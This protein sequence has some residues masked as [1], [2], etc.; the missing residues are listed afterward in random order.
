MIVPQGITTHIHEYGYTQET[1]LASVD[2]LVY[3]GS[4]PELS[5]SEFS[6]TAPIGADRRAIKGVLVGGCFVKPDPISRLMISTMERP[7][8]PKVIRLGIKFNALKMT[9]MAGQHDLNGPYEIAAIDSLTADRSAQAISGTFVLDPEGETTKMRCRAVLE[10][11]LLIE[12]E[13]RFS[14]QF[15]YKNLGK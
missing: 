15:R 8:T 9:E 6:G 2:L 13:Y 1:E 12:E 7:I 10:W 3:N 14:I 5:E 11:R 4:A